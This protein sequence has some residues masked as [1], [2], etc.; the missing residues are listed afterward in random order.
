[1][2]FEISE[3]YQK[4]PL[5]VSLVRGRGLAGLIKSITRHTFLHRHILAWMPLDVT[6]PAPNGQI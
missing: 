5:K 4:L 3:T 1:M 6:S 2:S